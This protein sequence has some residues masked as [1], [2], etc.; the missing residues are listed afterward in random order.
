MVS[1]DAHCWIITNILL[2]KSNDDSIEAK[3]G[4][5]LNRIQQESIHP[6]KILQTLIIRTN[7]GPARCGDNTCTFGIQPISFFEINYTFQQRESCLL[8]LYGVLS[9]GLF[10]C[11]EIGFYPGTYKNTQPGHQNTEFSRQSNSIGV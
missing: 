2:S 5:V 6:A 9:T 7:S 3:R 1:Y 4:V 8:L 11:R 10:A